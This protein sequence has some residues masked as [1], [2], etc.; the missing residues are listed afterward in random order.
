MVMWCTGLYCTVSSS[1]LT[2]CRRADAT[3]ILCTVSYYKLVKRCFLFELHQP[4][5]KLLEPPRQG[6]GAEGIF[7]KKE[8]KK[9]KKCVRVPPRHTLFTPRFR[10]ILR[11]NGYVGPSPLSS[12][13]IYACLFVFL[14]IKGCRHRKRPSGPHVRVHNSV[15]SHML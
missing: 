11:G 10:A 13:C 12:S 1:Y 14:I 2:W 15:I 9:E 7:G 5:G 8:K 4:P 6:P 3:I